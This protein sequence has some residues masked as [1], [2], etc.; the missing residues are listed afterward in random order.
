MDTGQLFSLKNKTAIVTGGSGVLGGSM[1]LALAKAGAKVA[2]L[3]RSEEKL[4]QMVKS[5]EETG[6]KGLALA[7]DVTNAEELS[8]ANKK[9][10]E[11]FGSIDILINGAGGNMP[12]ATVTPDQTIFDL[13]EDDLR[14]IVELNYIGTVLP[15]QAFAKSM[16]DRKQGVIINISSVAANLPLTRVMGYASSKAA[17]ENYTKWLAIEL[18]NKYGEGIRVNAIAP[19]FFLTEQNRSLLTQEDGSLTSRGKEIIAHT[20]F[21]RFGN[22]EDLHG[23]LLWLCSD[24][25]RFVTGTVVRVDGGFTAFSG[26]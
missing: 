20:P 23:A 24:A 3:G 14:K 18:A 11:H 13:K 10:L 9:V 15:V 26:V 2:V 22:P 5:I 25:S 1:A 4:R 6:A 21:R 7:A 19:G 8:A 16:T 17:I 12:G